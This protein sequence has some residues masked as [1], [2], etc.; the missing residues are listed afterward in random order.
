MPRSRSRKAPAKQT[1]EQTTE[2]N[3]HVESTE[4]PMD[5]IQTATTTE[6]ADP[7]QL[8]PK[9]FAK[10]LK[11]HVNRDGFWREHP[12]RTAELLVHVARDMKSFLPNISSKIMSRL[13]YGAC[14]LM[15][16]GGFL[17]TEV[18]HRETEDIKAIRTLIRKSGNR[19]ERAVAD[20]LLG[21]NPKSKKK[22]PKLEFQNR[23]ETITIFRNEWSSEGAVLAV[24]HRSAGMQ[25]SL[26]IQGQRVLDGPWNT[27]VHADGAILEPEAPWNSVCWYADKDGQYLELC[28]P[29]QKDVVQD[30]F[31]FMA[32]RVPM[33][34][35]ADCL[36]GKEP[37]EWQIQGHIPTP[38]QLGLEGHLKTRWQQC[39]GGPKSIAIAPLSSPSDP[40]TPGQ[41]RLSIKEGL[42]GFSHQRKAKRTMAVTCWT[43]SSQHELPLEPWRILTITS[44]RVLNS[45]ED[46]LAVRIPLA[47]KQC[48][49]FR[50]LEHPVRRAFLGHQTFDETIIGLFNKSGDIEPWLRVE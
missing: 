1:T 17:A 41:D 20:V 23:K 30:R 37:T 28:R 39:V 12:F 34:V 11:H 15:V 33:L 42:F 50:S 44:D 25:V 22:L 45:P 31:I 19:D 27:E 21:M 16:P 38:T 4:H 36:R 47:G 2:V 48:V 10:W 35:M 8:A 13:V 46:A 18:S 32:R 14:R 40:L 7:F 29:L 24:D 26:N 9:G 43:W 49:L 3:G 5:T 6:S